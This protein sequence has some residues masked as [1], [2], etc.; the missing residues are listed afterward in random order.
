VTHQVEVTTVLLEAYYLALRD[1]PDDQIS[2]RGELLLKTST[3]F[4]KPAEFRDSSSAEDDAPEA[5]RILNQAISQHGY[6]RHVDFD[7]KAINAAVRSLGGWQAAC[8]VTD[9]QEPF[10]RARFIKAY[11]SYRRA[12]VGDEAGKCLSGA[13]EADRVKRL[14]DGTIIE[15]A[16]TKREVKCTTT[17]SSSR[18][19]LIEASGSN[20]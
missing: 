5:Y 17:Q 4:P 9:E 11:L 3:Y 12:G 1:L 7:D 18:Q 6:M 2:Q 19:S 20:A 8:D 13:S 10:Y 16:V 15:Q 14:P